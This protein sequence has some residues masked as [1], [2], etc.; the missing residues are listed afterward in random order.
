MKMSS[1]LAGL[2]ISAGL[3]SPALAAETT[4]HAAA[5]QKAA[6]GDHRSAANIARNQYRHPVETLSFFGLRPDMTVVEIYPGG[7]GWYTE[8]LAP[9]LRE[10]GKLVAASYDTSS[11]V[12]YFKVNAATYLDKL[13]SRPD[14]Y[15]RVQVIEFG[16]PNKLSLGADNSADMVVT[17]RN[18]HNWV[19]AGTE[20]QMFGA[21]FKVLKPGGVLGVVAHRGT[22]EM[23]GKAWADKGY[24]SEAEVI[25][26]AQAA[27]FRLEGKSEVNAN[28]KDTKDYEKG[29]W[30]LPPTLEDGDK[31]RAKYLAIGESDRMTLKFV[32]P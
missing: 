22:A 5:L 11:G 7:G 21:M 25:R 4:D 30:A 32:K 8:V 23:T 10:K 9:F 19:N 17:F 1:S 31:D 18:V 6:A 24:Q 26:L 29:V 15:D 3:L 28:P 2:I 27:G 20:A 12:E 14:L 16:A 13:K